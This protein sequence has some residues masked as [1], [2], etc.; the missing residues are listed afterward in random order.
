MSSNSLALGE[1]VFCG[2]GSG[3]GFGFAGHNLDCWVTLEH[4]LMIDT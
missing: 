2:N 3:S 1:K 4:L